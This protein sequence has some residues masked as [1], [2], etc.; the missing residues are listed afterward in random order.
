MVN[1]HFG[2]REMFIISSQLTVHPTISSLRFDDF[3]DMIEKIKKVI[4]RFL[5][6][7]DRLFVLTGNISISFD[8]KRNSEVSKSFYEIAKNV[9]EGTITSCLKPMFKK[10]VFINPN[11]E[12]TSL[13]PN[14]SRLISIG[15]KDFNTELTC[16]GVKKYLTMEVQSTS[17]PPS[18]AR[19]RFIKKAL[20]PGGWV[21]ALYELDRTFRMEQ[22]YR[23]AKFFVLKG[24]DLMCDDDT[25]ITRYSE[26][27]RLLT[28]KP[29][30]SDADGFV[31]VSNSDEYFKNS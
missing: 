2:D 17:N 20:Q 18:D 28:Y 31:I 9:I 29:S 11:T 30:D 7:G 25:L 3:S 13:I 10:K 4:K 14:A 12:S 22:E 16:S 15:G 26:L 6:Q 1:I 8:V 19:K 23:Y 21:D 24:V 27:M 5:L